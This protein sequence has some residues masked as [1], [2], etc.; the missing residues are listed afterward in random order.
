MFL[1]D[2]KVILDT[3]RISTDDADDWGIEGEPR[4]FTRSDPVVE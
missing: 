4:P 1:Q 2:T 3:L